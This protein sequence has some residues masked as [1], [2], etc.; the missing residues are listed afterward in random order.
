MNS[1][2]LAF[3]AT[4]TEET[5]QKICGQHLRINKMNPMYANDTNP[6]IV[7]ELRNDENA[8]GLSRM[9]QVTRMTG[10]QQPL[11]IEG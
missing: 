2:L 6:G 1:R 8:G 9:V 7:N 10:L 4:K 5:N 3:R 11:E